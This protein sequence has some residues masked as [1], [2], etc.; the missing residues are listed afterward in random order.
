MI[1]NIS[2]PRAV[3]AADDED[4]AGEDVAEAAEGEE[5]ATEE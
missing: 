3:L 4:E 1:A 2:A 5:E